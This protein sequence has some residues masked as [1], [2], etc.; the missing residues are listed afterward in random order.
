MH[1]KRHML[2]GG[3]GTMGKKETPAPYCCG[4]HMVPSYRYRTF[5]IIYRTWVCNN[6]GNKKDTRL[7]VNEEK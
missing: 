4:E 6:C 5:G 7:Y 2:V 3:E 1:Y